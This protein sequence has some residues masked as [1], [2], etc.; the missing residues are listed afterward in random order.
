M[1]QTA[2]GAVLGAGLTLAILG[3]WPDSTSVF[4]QRASFAGPEAGQVLA[5]STP[6]GSERQQLTLIDPVSRTLGVY[7][8]ESAT[9]AVTLK[10][11]RNFHWDL[12]LLEFNGHSP[13][14][15]EIRSMLPSR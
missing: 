12:Q 15:Q 2:I 7:H 3:V 14:P 5:F 10:S 11:V 8:V 13:R 6:V 4:A 1:R 9:G